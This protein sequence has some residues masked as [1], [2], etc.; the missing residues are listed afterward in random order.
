MKTTTRVQFE[1]SDKS[2]K[3]LKW[4]KKLSDAGSYAEVVRTS[5][6]LYEFMIKSTDVKTCVYT[7]PLDSPPGVDEKSII[8]F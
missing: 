6:R 1:L 3:R 2:M 7:R 5:L 8:L 4:L